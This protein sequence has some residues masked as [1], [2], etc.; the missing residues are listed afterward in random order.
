MTFSPLH[1]LRN[2]LFHRF[3]VQNGQFIMY[4]FHVMYILRGWLTELSVQIHLIDNIL[5]I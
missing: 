4:H 5:L 2:V 1:E 3:I